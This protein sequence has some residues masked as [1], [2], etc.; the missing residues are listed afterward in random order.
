MEQLKS[1]F[2]L[3]DRLESGQDYYEIRLESIGGLG[4][5]CAVRC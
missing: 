2:A 3:E 4:L 1:K 5:I